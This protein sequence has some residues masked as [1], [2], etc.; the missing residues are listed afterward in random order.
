MPVHAAVLQEPGELPEY[1]EHPD[2]V[3]RPVPPSSG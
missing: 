3:R 1:R 2:P